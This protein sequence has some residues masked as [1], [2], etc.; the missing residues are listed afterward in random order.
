[1]SEGHGGVV[2]GSKISGGARNILVEDGVMSS[3]D[4][5][6][7]IRFK[8]NSHRGGVIESIYV[9]NVKVGGREAGYDPSRLLLLRRRHEK[10]RPDS[11]QCR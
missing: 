2:M 9:R 7:A 10:V 6:R 4:L 5:D 1:M 3:P 8:T 11:A